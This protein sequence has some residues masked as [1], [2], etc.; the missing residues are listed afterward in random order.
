MR[1][2][3]PLTRRRWLG[4]AGAAGAAAV[5]G[6]TRTTTEARTPDSPAVLV[7][8]TRSIGCMS[9]EAA[10]AA[11]NGLPD[12]S[13]AG[14]ADPF[15]NRRTTTVEAF[16][17]V[18]RSSEPTASGEP[19]FTKS[20]WMRCLDPG[21]ASA[22]PARAL[23]KTVAGPVVYHADRCLGCRYC[24]VACPFDVPRFEY[25]STSPRI[26]KCSFC[27]DR[28]ARRQLPA[29]VEACPA[30]TLQFGARGALIEEARRRIYQA[31]PSAYVPAIYGEAEV[32]GT[33]WLYLSDVPFDRLGFRVDLGTTPPPERA[34]TALAA[35][36]LVLTLWPPLLMGLYA[37]ARRQPAAAARGANAE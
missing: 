16:T 31:P 30:G 29:C 14:D 32:G 5:V 27:A 3:Q 1:N 6:F 2:D 26:R 11:S 37:I 13:P 17:V 25:G 8:T 15:E 7:D 20:P 22:C 33:S 19:R 10:C 28:Q 18:N 34:R 21:C 23:E 24:M 4:L 12:P 36:P 35:V 9:C